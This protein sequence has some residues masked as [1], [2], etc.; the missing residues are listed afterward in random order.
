MHHR[1]GFVLSAAVL[2]VAVAALFTIAG[3]Q[4]KAD[5]PNSA[6]NPYHVVSNWAKLPQGRRWGMAIGVD[7]DRDGRS[8]P[9]TKAEG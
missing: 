7:I 3:R 1:M 6:A 8:S 5:D 2:G 9:R 4:A